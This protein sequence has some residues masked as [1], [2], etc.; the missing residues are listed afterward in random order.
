MWDIDFISEDDFITH[1]ANTI[2]VYDNNLVSYNIQ[3]F[4]SNIVD[5]INSY[6]TSLFTDSAGK[7]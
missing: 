1:V 5:P 4:N 3:Q 7:K 2:K 6:S